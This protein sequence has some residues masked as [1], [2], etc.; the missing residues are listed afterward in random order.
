[1][2][3]ITL[4]DEG[5][6]VVSASDGGAALA[7]LERHQPSLILLDMRMPVMDGWSFARAYAAC[8]GPHAPVVVMTAAVDATK[9]AREVDARAALAKPFDLDRLLEIVAVHALPAPPA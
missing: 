8:S 2:L 4:T 7:L 3:E 9:W 1:M 5:Y 6:D